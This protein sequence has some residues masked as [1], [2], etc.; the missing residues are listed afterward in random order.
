MAE[1]S[2]SIRIERSADEVWKV[3]SDAGNIADWVPILASSRMEGDS[4]VCELEGGGRLVER[5]L[6]NDDAARTIEYDITES[7][8]T[9]DD[10]LATVR[11]DDDG[12]AALVTWTMR[13]EPAEMAEM[14]R[15]VNEGGLAALKEYCER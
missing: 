2:N 9:F 12:D 11:V 7:P 13:I 15:P 4:R 10:Y 5:I 8:L 6:R 3:V 14:M 1:I